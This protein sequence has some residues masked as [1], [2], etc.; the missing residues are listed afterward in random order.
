MCCGHSAHE[1]GCQAQGLTG[2]SRRWVS[3]RTRTLAVSPDPRGDLTRRVS[4][5]NESR[6]AFKHKDVGTRFLRP[7]SI[8][9]ILREH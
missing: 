3:L 5:R 1:R 9:R 6:E 7:K 2:R 8:K 4:I